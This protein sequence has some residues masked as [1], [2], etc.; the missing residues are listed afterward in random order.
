[1]QPF[2]NEDLEVK[3]TAT[4]LSLKCK[5]QTILEGKL[6]E[7]VRRPSGPVQQNPHRDPTSFEAACSRYFR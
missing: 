2:P 6:H 1:M 3:V 7:K 4:R 5:G